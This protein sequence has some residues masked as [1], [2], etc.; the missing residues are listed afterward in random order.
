MRSSAARLRA[1]PTQ[2]EAILAT[3]DD[4]ALRA[5]PGAGEWSAIEVAGH[6][7]DKMQVWCG[8]VERI[9]REEQPFLPSYDQDSSVR[10]HAYQSA[11]RDA[12]LRA[13][14]E[15]CERFAALVETLPATALGRGGMHAEMGPITLE[16]CV[17]EPLDS[18]AAHLAQMR[19]AIAAADRHA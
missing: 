11:D 4:T 7:V 16:Q 9:A 3:A 13:L 14:R 19:A 10:E 8:R 2:V 1:L 12:L 17:W 6:L 5:R 15:A 18:A